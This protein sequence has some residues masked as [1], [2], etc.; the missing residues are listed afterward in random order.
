MNQ[1]ILQYYD[2]GRTGLI[3]MLCQSILNI[4]DSTI[5]KDYHLSESLLMKKGESASTKKDI[6]AS[7]NT[8]T[9]TVGKTQIKGRINKGFF[10]GSPEEA[11]IST[12]AFIA[13]KHGSYHNY[14]DFIGFDISWRRRFLDVMSGG[15][16]NDREASDDLG[17][18]LSQSK[19]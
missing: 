3:V 4:D 17:R 1:S 5:V 6:T 16:D 10:S 7:I 12:L 14:L 19:L 18:P 8:S 11:M 13:E 9:S 2:H 15:N